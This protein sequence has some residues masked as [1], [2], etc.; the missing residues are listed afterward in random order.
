MGEQCAKH[1]TSPDGWRHS[2]GDN[3]HAGTLFPTLPQTGGGRRGRGHTPCVYTNHMDCKAEVGR[4][5]LRARSSFPLATGGT[6]LAT[7]GGMFE[8]FRCGAKGKASYRPL[9]LTF[10]P[11]IRSWKLVRSSTPD[12]CSSVSGREGDIRVALAPGWRV[13]PERGRFWALLRFPKVPPSA[14]RFLKHGSGC[15]TKGVA[16]EQTKCATS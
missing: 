6:W 11:V 10:V 16:E 8:P 15:R 1:M 13:R 14:A 4:T 12:A 2:A 5:V 3:G 9:V 7:T